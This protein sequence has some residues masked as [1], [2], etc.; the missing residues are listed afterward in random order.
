MLP[1][2]LLMDII[3]KQHSASARNKPSVYL[4][5]IYFRNSPELARKLQKGN[6][7]KNDSQNDRQEHLHSRRKQAKEI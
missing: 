7:P 4:L 2:M 1:K 5:R 6:Q 3:S